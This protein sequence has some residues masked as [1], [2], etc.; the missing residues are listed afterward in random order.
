M[1]MMSIAK[2]DLKPGQ[3]EG[4]WLVAGHVNSAELDLAKK[5]F[6]LV[7]FLLCSSFLYLTW[8]ASK[9]LDIQRTTDLA[10][11]YHDNENF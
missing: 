4:S 3:D 9:C 7:A 2:L 5:I 8:F 10:C 1:H 11:D 6:R